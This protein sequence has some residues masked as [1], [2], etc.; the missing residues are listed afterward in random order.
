MVVNDCI[1]K[2]KDVIQ[3]VVTIIICAVMAGIYDKLP[4][5]SYV[6]AFVFFIAVFAVMLVIHIIGVTVMKNGYKVSIVISLVAVEVF[7]GA[8]AMT[9]PPKFYTYAP[10]QYGD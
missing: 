10:Y 8:F 6:A 5:N 9:G 2:K 4:V 3:A 1:K 7:I